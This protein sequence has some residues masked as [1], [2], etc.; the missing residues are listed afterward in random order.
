MQPD[1]QQNNHL[2]ADLREG[3]AFVAK[4]AKHVRIDYDALD[5]YV[6]RLHD[7]TDEDLLSLEYHF[8]GTEE[9]I[10][11]YILVLDAI[12]F[13]SGYKDLLADEGWALSQGDIYY[14]VSTL[15]KDQ[16]NA[17][18]ALSADDLAAMQVEDVAKILKL[19][20]S[21]DKMAEFATLCTQSISE[22]GQF[23]QDRYDGRILNLVHAAGGSCEQLISVLSALRH[24]Q[25]VH[26]YQGREIPFLKRAQRV[27]ID[28]EL[29]YNHIGKTL[30]DDL[31]KLT[32]SADNAVPHVLHMDG[33]LQYTPA[34]QQ[35]ID[36]H[37][38][39]PS[40]SDEEIEIRA[41]AGQAVE[42]LAALGK[43]RAIDIDHILW[44]KSVEEDVYQTKPTHK[45]LTN[46]Y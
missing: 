15:L 33:I 9:E 31:D 43:R 5:Q 30:F 19:D 27:A 6:I 14:T 8:T 7:V 17:H 3:F 12:N 40:G 23:V 10:A 22:L 24:F 21:R 1:L 4:N 26:D 36:S 20:L 45:T 37:T 11:S 28:L 34:L 16:Y 35:K 44:H 42:L 46:F 25:D 32:V 13:G 41:M 2:M 18:G 29:A 38:L 39:L